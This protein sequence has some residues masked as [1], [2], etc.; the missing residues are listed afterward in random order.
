MPLLLKSCP[1]LQTL[2]FKGLIHRVTNR[3]G[4]ACACNPGQKKRKR[5]KKLKEVCCLQTCRVKV[6]EI[7]DYGGCFKELKQMIH[8]VDNLEC[9]EILKVGVDPDK[10]SELVRANVMPLPRLSSK[11]TIQFI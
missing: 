6:L 8:F 7:S 11:C 9:L 2:V 1:N 5:M 3:C 10:N 4:D